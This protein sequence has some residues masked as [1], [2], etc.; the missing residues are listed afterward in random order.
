MKRVL[1]R[2]TVTICLL[3]LVLSSP[4]FSAQQNRIAL[5]IGNSGYKSNPLKNPVN[6]AGDIADALQEVGFNVMLK[7]NVDHRTMKKAIR[8]FGKKLRSGGVG[9]FYYAGHGLQVGGA[10]FLIPIGADIEDEAD[11]E[12]EAVDAA[13]VLAQM[14]N[15]GNKLN[16][17]ILDACRD[18]PFAR[19]FRSGSRGLAKMDAPTGSILAY[20]TSPG[21]VAADGDGRNGLYTSA[22]LKHMKMPG[23]TIE[24]MFKQVR[25]DVAN[26]SGNKQVPWE[27]SSLTGDF[28]F[29][30]DRGITVTKTKKLEQE[31]QK[32]TTEVYKAPQRNVE[33]ELEYWKSIKN[34]N[35]S[36]EFELY[37]EE[38][39]NGKFASLA[40]M[41]IRKLREKKV[42]AAIVPK[43][44]KITKPR[45]SK[46][47][48]FVNTN[49]ENAR[50]KIL[51]ISSK[52]HQGIELRPGEYH[53]QVSKFQY[54]TRKV[55]VSIK[56]NEDKKLNIRLKKFLGDNPDF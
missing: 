5:V 37:L 46:P 9:L 28:Y 35:D 25:I 32:F 31:G 56:A 47:R 53:V 39:P 21:S 19:S 11:I 7:I 3:I 22:L 29:N 30:T 15:A 38:F 13:R 49:P 24:K 36:D 55:W 33:M 14:E 50:I 43:V 42:V 20:A 40:R 41:K 23:L 10:N 2:V 18:N 26:G 51:N 52:F 1:L 44:T 54:L 8:R 6:D 48:L 12:F 34:S 4:T 16:I 17:I 45:S 27:S